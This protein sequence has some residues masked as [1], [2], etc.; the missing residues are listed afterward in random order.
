MTVV[1]LGAVFL[2][3]VALLAAATR[4]FD[5]VVSPVTLFGLGLFLYVVAIPMEVTLTGNRNL[6]LRSTIVIPQEVVTQVVPLAFVALIAFVVGYLLI[7]DRT[8][9]TQPTFSRADIAHA[10]RALGLCAALSVL[11]MLVL[12]GAQLIATRDYTTSYTQRYESPL[13]AVGLAMMQVLLAM[14]GFSLARFGRHPFR[15]AVAFAGLL[16]MWGLYSNQKTPIVLAGLVALGYLTT[17]V[18]KP[19]ALAVGTSVMV[20]PVLLAVAAISF[21]TFRGGGVLQLAGRSGYLTTIEPAGPFVS[22]VDEML[23]RGSSAPASGFGESVIQG[24]VGWVPRAV[25]SDRPLDIAE[26][27]ARTRIPDWQPGEGYGYS[28]F[29]EAVHQGGLAGVAAY[30]L[31][32]GLVVALLRNLLLRRRHDGSA[33]TI[34]AESF[35]HVVVLLLL[36]TL[37]RG[38]L[39]AFVTTFVQYSVALVLALVMTALLPRLLQDSHAVGSDPDPVEV[40]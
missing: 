20:M 12:F 19:S 4:S 28:P 5:H 7:V 40:S 17:R 25:W 35:Y 1:V 30:F 18:R 37:F 15:D 31:L 21:S 23:D 6:S 11:V 26:Q 9:F 36:F 38:P 33:L 32:L 27:F 39:Q 14:Y 10:Q 16:S 22:I 29:A 13:Y 2:V 8:P 24:L 3:L 34:V